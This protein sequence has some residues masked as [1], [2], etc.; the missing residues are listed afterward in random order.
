MAAIKFHEYLIWIISKNQYRW[1]FILNINN[2]IDLNDNEVKHLLLI[3]TIDYINNM[4]DEIK[5]VSVSFKNIKTKL[6][7][8]LY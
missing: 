5:R 4:E 6:I 8:R 1:K 3:N 7:F 2:K